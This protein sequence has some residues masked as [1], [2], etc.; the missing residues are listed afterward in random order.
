MF[1]RT[2]NELYFKVQAKAL[3][4]VGFGLANDAPTN[5]ADYDV[6]VGGVYDNGSC[7]LKV[8]C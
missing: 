7:Y 3:G 4:W 2:S 6:A 1:N 5:M 8:T